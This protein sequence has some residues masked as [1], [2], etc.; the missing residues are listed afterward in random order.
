MYRFFDVVAIV[1]QDHTVFGGISAESM[2]LLIIQIEPGS[3]RTEEDTSFFVL[4][5]GRYRLVSQSVFAA[6]EDS[7]VF[8][9]IQVDL[10]DDSSCCYPYII[11]RVDQE[12][13][14][15]VLLASF[16]GLGDLFGIEIHFDTSP[17]RQ[18]NQVFVFP[19]GHLIDTVAGFYGIRRVFEIRIPEPFLR[20]IEY[21]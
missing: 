3:E 1:A 2:V 12:T 5:D 9:V 14:I 18:E 17:L 7:P 8:L 6:T 10:V 19:D 4:I 11:L 13:M 16:E 21:G 20:D 15:T